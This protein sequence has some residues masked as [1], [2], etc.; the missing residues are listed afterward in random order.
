[1][2]VHSSIKTWVKPLALSVF[3]FYDVSSFFSLTLEIN[4]M[5][6]AIIATATALSDH[7]PAIL[8]NV[9]KSSCNPQMDPTEESGNDTGLN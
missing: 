5:S 2:L 7:I 3:F 8:I 9:R 1:M 6:S 4:K